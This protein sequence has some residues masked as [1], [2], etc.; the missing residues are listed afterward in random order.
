MIA[1][2]R[3]KKMRRLLQWVRVQVARWVHPVSKSTY[4]QRMNEG[5]GT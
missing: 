2:E 3:E 5:G 4:A 1:M